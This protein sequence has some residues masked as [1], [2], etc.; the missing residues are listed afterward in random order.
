MIKIFKE[1]L[2]VKDSFVNVA[3]KL[4]AGNVAAQL[5]PLIFAPVLTRLYSPEDFGGFAVYMSIVS[6]VAVVSTGRYEL[7]IML[8]QKEE[9][10]VNVCALTAFIVA[11]VS[12]AVFIVILIF[13][14]H[15]TAILGNDKILSWL[16][17]IPL[18]VFL[19]GIYQIFYYW[20]LMRRMFARL[21]VNKVFQSSSTIGVQIGVGQFSAT[22]GTLIEGQIAGQG[23]GTVL[24]GWQ[25]WKNDRQKLNLI[26]RKSLAAQAN[27]YE[28]FPRYS[29]FA[30]FINTLSNRIPNLLLNSFF[31]AASAGF[32][33]LTQMCLDSPAS[34]VGSSVFD[35]F[36]ERASRA[37]KVQGNCKD[38]YVKMFKGLL[39]I[40]VAVFIPLFFLSPWLVPFVFGA[41][42][43]VAG[44][45]ARFF[46]IMLFFKF[47]ASPLSYVLYIAEK[48]N[49]DLIWQICLFIVTVIS[50][51]YGVYLRDAKVSVLCFSLSY[52]M[53]YIL[54]LFL[55][56]RFAQG[57]K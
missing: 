33:A 39:L 30:D 2:V 1:Q 9:D 19:T 24:L 22:A 17:F 27:R 43:K 11:V 26:N 38:V 28:K 31:G 47:I 54:Y 42:W 41:K 15:I 56:Y 45:Y 12:S 52:S 32:F 14:N 3:L 49:Y 55:S 4:L 5:I 46:S 57:N 20:S 25:I 53:M 18:A 16:Y 21:S 7:A 23:I 13:K 29:L 48:Q 10:A 51:M 44:E 6:I 36:K 35:V 34:L 40:A 50:I 8:P 37:Y